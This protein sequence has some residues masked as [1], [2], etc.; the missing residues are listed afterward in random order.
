[1]VEFA[2]KSSYVSRNIGQAHSIVNLLLMNKPSLEIEYCTQCRFILRAAW[3]AQELL[4]T[5][6]TKVGEVVLIPAT[7]GAFEIR[8]DGEVLHSRK[9]APA[10][11]E[12]K[13]IKQ[14]VR[15]RIAP[16]MSLGHDSR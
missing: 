7:G 4:M 10:F 13:Q 3:I 1:M 2:Y 16:G 5:F 8:L 11:R 6:Q 15:D 14:L 9:E 12:S